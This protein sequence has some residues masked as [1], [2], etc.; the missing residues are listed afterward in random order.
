MEERVLL[1]AVM[2]AGEIM[3]VSGAEVSRVEDTMNRMLAK[4]G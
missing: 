4:S 2:R 1:E 3:L